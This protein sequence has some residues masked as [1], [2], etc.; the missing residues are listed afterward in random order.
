[1]S[2]ETL[3]LA[4]TGDEAAFRTLV[5]PYR[6]ELHVHCYR[7]LGSFHD[8]D[9][10]LQETLLAAWSALADFEGRSSL[11]TWL[12]RIATNRC[13]NAVRDAG[14]RPRPAPVPPFDPPEP[15]RRSEVTWLQPYPDAL[16]DGRLASDAGPESRWSAREAIELAFIEA[17]QHLPA[18]QTAVVVLR[19][20]LGFPTADVAAMLGTT[21]VAVKA[22]LQ[23]ARA[24]LHGRDP[25]GP[26]TPASSAVEQ[27]VSRRF[28]EAFAAD[29]IDGV[30]ALLTDDAWLAMP[31]APHQYQGRAAIAAFLEASVAW[32]PGRRFRLVPTRANGQPAY[33]CYLTQHDGDAQAAG[34]LV[35]TVAGEQISAITRFLDEAVVTSFGFPRERHDGTAGPA[36]H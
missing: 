25:V 9:D 10:V 33:G 1:V 2:P 11:R 5:D 15:T 17:L 19:E 30:V 18:R 7:I 24:T 29:D 13:L 32:R 31:P 3:A 4:R 35:L 14:R 20:V 22:A 23:R 21:P 16:L 8:A 26:A 6:R 28:A 12:Y 34:V 36:D 27:E